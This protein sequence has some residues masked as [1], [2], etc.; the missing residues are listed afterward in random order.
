MKLILFNFTDYQEGTRVRRKQSY[1][2]PVPTAGTVKPCSIR[3]HHHCGQTTWVDQYG[4]TQIWVEYDTPQRRQRGRASRLVRC[5]W[6][7]APELEVLSVPR[8]S[9]IQRLSKLLHSMKFF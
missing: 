5:E 4:T 2:H 8:L 7:S 1:H 9:L 6:V 3:Q